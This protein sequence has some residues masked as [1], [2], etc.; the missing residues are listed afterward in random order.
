MEEFVTSRL[1]RWEGKHP[2]EF[3]F[4]KMA[5]LGFIPPSSKSLVTIPKEINN[6]QNYSENC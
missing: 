1:L 2:L 4:G 6:I 3:E 5:Q